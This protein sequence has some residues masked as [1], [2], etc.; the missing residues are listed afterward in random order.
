MAKCLPWK[1]VWVERIGSDGSFET[2]CAVC[3]ETK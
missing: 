1:H 3:G 2:V